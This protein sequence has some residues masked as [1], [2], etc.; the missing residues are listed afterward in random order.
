MKG[1]LE[2]HLVGD[3]WLGLAVLHAD[4]LVEEGALVQGELLVQGWADLE[5]GGGRGTNAGQHLGLAEGPGKGMTRRPC[6]ALQVRQG[7]A[8]WPQ[9][10]GGGGL[11]WHAVQGL[12]G[13]HH[14][15]GRLARLDTFRLHRVIVGLRTEGKTR[16]TKRTVKIG[17]TQYITQLIYI[18]EIQVCQCKYITQYITQL[19]H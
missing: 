12:I 4:W 14:V 17:I 7:E 9:T 2:S 1:S 15:G 3:D 18:G 6:V 11:G 16:G 13:G 8:S 10:V 5:G 19:I